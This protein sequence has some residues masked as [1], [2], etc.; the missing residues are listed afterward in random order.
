MKKWFVIILAVF[1]A[2]CVKDAKKCTFTLP[3]ASAPQAERI[4]V[5]NY[6]TSKGITATLHPNGFYYN[7]SNPGTGSKAEPCNTVSLQYTARLTN[8]SIFDATP[9]SAFYTDK[10]GT[11]LPGLQMGM[12]LIGK[13]GTVQLYIPPSLGFGAVPYPNAINPVVPANSVL[14]YDL[15]ISALQ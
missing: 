9:G 2:A 12:S 13:G 8:D 15:T 10:V 6:L 14:V 4:I 1:F 11:F 3:T 7:I 5:Q